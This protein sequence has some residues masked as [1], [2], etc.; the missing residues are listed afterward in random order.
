MRSDILSFAA[1]A[2]SLVSPALGFW[3]L[4]CQGRLGVAPMDPLVNP[5]ERAAH[6][7]A[8]HGAR[9]FGLSVT[10]D[11]LLDSE[12]TS[13]AVTQDKSIYWTPTLYFMYPNGTVQL[14]EQVGGTLVYYLPRGDNVKAFPRGFRLLAGDT[15]RRNFSLAEPDPPKSSWTAEDM[16]QEALSQRAIGFNCL[17]YAI[18]AEP[19]L[20]RHH[21]PDKS[22]L[23]E[24]CTEGIRAE[25]LF[26]S[27]WNG[28]DL[29]SDDHMSHMAYPNLVDTG[30]CPE[31][32]EHRL[33]TLMYEIIWNTYAF[34]D[35][36]G[37]F[38]W[39]NGD[40]TGY[41]FHADFI[42]GW[43]DGVLERAVEQCTDDSG[44]VEK[45]P[46]FELQ[47]QEKQNQ[48]TMD[49]P[50][51]LAKE[52]FDFSENGLPGGVPVIRG[53]GYAKDASP[54]DEDQS[55]S[56]PLPTVPYTPAT[57]VSSVRAPDPT[58]PAQAAPEPAP[59]EF[60]S[61]SPSPSAKELEDVINVNMPAPEPTP[62]PST[63]PELVE[64]IIG[65]TT[66][67][68]GN[69][70]YEIVIYQDVV[71]TTVEIPADATPAVD[72]RKRHGHGRFHVRRSHL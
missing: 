8:I 60:Y 49:M 43:E 28:K 57:S 18:A 61:S 41:G 45:C 16:T 6:V 14:V 40:P 68:E 66:Y 30:E 37:E 54:D 19:A 33:V 42:E 67:T 55:T 48:C 13:C 36:E 46:V 22:Y 7:H 47:S 31:G 25:I 15:Y 11:L 3:R 39:S 23:D 69:T 38:V 63:L 5:G 59:A 27:C 58:P 21:M 20:Y 35:V 29:D 10:A 24:H 26:P 9:N 34:K 44:L 53:P 62:A 12:C 17:N 4:P 65:T 56:R 72:K 1:A 50:S 51:F 71:T 52:R 32:F 64:G 70:V 2:A